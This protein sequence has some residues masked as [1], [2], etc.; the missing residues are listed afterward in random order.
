M[1]SPI[2]NTE[3]VTAPQVVTENSTQ[4]LDDNLDPVLNEQKE[5]DAPAEQHQDSETDVKDVVMSPRL[6]QSQN[7]VEK[8]TSNDAP[9]IE[10]SRLD[11]TTGLKDTLVDLSCAF[12]EVEKIAQEVEE[13]LSEENDEMIA[14]E[15]DEMI[16]QENV[17]NTPAGDSLNEAGTLCEDCGEAGHFVSSEHVV[18]C[19][20][21]GSC[22]YVDYVDNEEYVFECEVC[23]DF[24]NRFDVLTSSQV[25]ALEF[26]DHALAVAH[27]N[28]C[29]DDWVPERN[30]EYA[31]LQLLSKRPREEQM[32]E[33]AQADCQLAHP[34]SDGTCTTDC[35]CS[36]S[37]RKKLM[38]SPAAAATTTVKQT[39]SLGQ[40]KLTRS[41]TVPAHAD[42]ATL[43][44]DQTQHASNTTAVA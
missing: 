32:S 31:Q 34:I 29:I 37:A 26:G 14:Q 18:V 19:E 1:S 22:D 38:M 41:I 33:D 5:S 15:N 17:A 27:E 20:N 44:L 36:P 28:A 9:N 16:A 43:A 42:E 12:S 23:T 3:N 13:S 4:N 39:H 24:R 7:E 25:C 6:S 8:S 30:P 21:C 11:A 35:G 2:E 10:T 40:R